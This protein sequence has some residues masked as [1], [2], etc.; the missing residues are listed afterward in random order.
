MVVV[1]VVVV[2]VVFAAVSGAVAAVDAAAVVVVVASAAFHVAR[3]V[4]VVVTSG[5]I[6]EHS[7][8][9]HLKTAVG[10]RKTMDGTVS[11]VHYDEIPVLT[12]TSSYLLENP[13]RF[14]IYLILVH[15]LLRA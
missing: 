10:G 1:V 12:V 2:V 4:D 6:F 5:Y 15:N 11:R 3:L 14:Q 8:P 9:A 7:H 13:A